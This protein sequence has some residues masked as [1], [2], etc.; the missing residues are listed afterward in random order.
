MWA[1]ASFACM[2]VIFLASAQVAEDSAKLSGGLTRVSFGAV[3]RW[4]SPDGQEM[5]EPLFIAFETFLRKA[6]HILVFLLLG[7]CAANTV[8]RATLCRAAA[9]VG[10]ASGEA[11][12]SGSAGG[13]IASGK[14]VSGKIVS[15]KRIFWISLIWCSAY[16]ALDELHQYFV[17]GRTMMLKDWVI[18]VM[19]SLIG[20]GLVLLYYRK[21]TRE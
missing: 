4:L 14:I 18:D 12:C 21:K 2:L 8:R 1:A 7:V 3:W 15:V 9:S 5:P 20:I 16:G 17:P 13:E 10:S 6:A 11:A 19:G